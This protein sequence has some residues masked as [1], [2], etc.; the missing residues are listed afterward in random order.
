MTGTPG[1]SCPLHYRYRPDELAGA[2]TIAADSAWIVGGL[3]G[4]VEALATIVAQVQRERASGARVA[5]VFN[6]DFHWFDIDPA[7]FATVQDAVLAERAITGNIELELA[8][9]DPAAG[10]GCAYPDFVDQGTV[11]R[12]NRIIERLQATAATLPGARERLAALP[13]LLRVQ[14]GG[15]VTGI[16]H[17]DPGSI[18]GWQFAIESVNDVERPLAASTVTTWA[19]AARVG[20]FACTHTCLPW[21]ARFGDVAVI[22][23]GSAGMPNFAGD[24]RGIV[25]RIAGTGQAHAQAL[26]AV[27]HGA[28]RWEAIAVDYDHA[29]WWQRFLRAWPEGSPAHR[30]YARRIRQGPAFTPAQ[31]VP[32]VGGAV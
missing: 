10:C 25:T 24:P 11:E 21:A 6:G 7:D 3:Y 12:S 2:E 9:P 20:A 31:A 23:N 27:E 30:S 26:Y 22:N 19:G 17:G 28:T 29:R 5:L 18:A 1:R 13:R 14:V 16:I 15:T 32:R 4:N 8:Q